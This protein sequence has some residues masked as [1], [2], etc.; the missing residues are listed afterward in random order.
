MRA[1]LHKTN[2]HIQKTVLR[3]THLTLF[4]LAFRATVTA[5]VRLRAIAFAAEWLRTKAELK[6]IIIL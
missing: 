5:D 6:L 2:G 4:R 1:L 3:R